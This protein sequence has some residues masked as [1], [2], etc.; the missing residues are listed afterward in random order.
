MVALSKPRCITVETK[1]CVS[2]AVS[3]NGYNKVSMWTCGCIV[4]NL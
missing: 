3:V 1:R 4:V 2:D